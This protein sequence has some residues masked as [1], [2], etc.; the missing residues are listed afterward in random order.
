MDVRSQGSESPLLHIRVFRKKMIQKSVYLYHNSFQ[1]FI[2][3]EILFD[4]TSS[5]KDL[6]LR[7]NGPAQESP[8]REGREFRSKQKRAEGPAHLSPIMWSMAGLSRAFI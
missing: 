4:Q 1:G 3:R 6:S 7:A 5:W 2:F 8:A